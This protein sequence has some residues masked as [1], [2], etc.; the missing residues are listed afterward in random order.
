VSFTAKGKMILT[1]A[2]RLLEANDQILSIGGA[3]SDGRPVR[4]GL[5]TLCL[6][7]FLENRRIGEE[8]AM[9]TT[10]FCDQSSDLAKSFADGYLDLACL[11]NFPDDIGELIHSWEEEVAWVRSRHFVLRH[12]SPLPVIGCPGSWQD[13]MMISAIE[14]AG[15]AYRIVFTSSDHHA[16]TTAVANGIGLML[17]PRRF[18]REPL[19]AAIEYY[20]PRMRAVRFGLFSRPGLEDERAGALISQLRGLSSSGEGRA[21]TSAGSK[22]H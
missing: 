11:V 9:Q 2:R 15:L 19:L 13:D 6:D 20:L 1:Q 8:L 4:L 18:V 10:F 16:R 5:P 22:T 21:S 3:L 17:M 14:K 12:G 7:P